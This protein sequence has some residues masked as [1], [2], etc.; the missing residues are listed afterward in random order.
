M[1]CIGTG[2]LEGVSKTTDHIQCFRDF[3]SVFPSDSKLSDRRL[4]D[5]FSTFWVEAFCSHS[6]FLASPSSSHPASFPVHLPPPLPPSPPRLPPPL[7]FLTLA[8]LFHPH[9]YLHSILAHRRYPTKSRRFFFLSI[10][11]CSGVAKIWYRIE[12]YVIAF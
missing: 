8:V 4:E 11:K 3:A 10:S 1:Y 7:P 6:A 9:P 12:L 2:A 5:F